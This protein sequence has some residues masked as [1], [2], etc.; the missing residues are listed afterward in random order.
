MLRLP[1]TFTW[2][3]AIAPPPWYIAFLGGRG[4][5]LEGFV[6]LRTTVIEYVE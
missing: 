4:A 2:N 3:V 5:V 1:G 6:G